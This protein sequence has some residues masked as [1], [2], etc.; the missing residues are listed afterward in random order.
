MAK[1]RSVIDVILGEA[2]GATPQERL[3]EM[4]GIASV[5]ANRAAATGKT[6]EQV[7][8]EDG[9]FDAYNKNIPKGAEAYRGLAEQALGYVKQSGPVTSAT[10]FSASG[11]KAPAKG[12][13]VAQQG[14]ATTFYDGKYGANTPVNAAGTFSPP[15]SG[16][17]GGWGFP[18]MAPPTPVTTTA[19]TGTPGTG[20]QL[21]DNG[22]TPGGNW[23]IAGNYKP[24]VDPRLTDILSTAAA[25]F[26]G[27]EVKAFSGLRPG[28]KRQHGR[29]LATDVK[30]VDKTTGVEVPD[31]QS[32]EG[33]RTYEQFAQVAKEVQHEKYPELDKGF[34]WGGYFSGPPG[35]YGA[36]DLMHFDLGG[37][38][39]LHMAGGT[40][41]HGLTEAQRKNFPGAVSIGMDTIENVPLPE[42]R[43]TQLAGMPDNVGAPVSNPK[44]QLAQALGGFP[45]V[46]NSAEAA[47]LSPAVPGVAPQTKT[48]SL[49]SIAVPSDS[50]GA[51]NPEKLS[52]LGA[53][54]TLTGVSPIPGDWTMGGATPTVLDRM[55][56]PT[57][58]A[59]P[60][61]VADT[62]AQIYDRP[63]PVDPNYT[64]PA[65]PT[66]TVP[67]RLISPTQMGV[68]TPPDVP[69]SPTAT[70]PTVTSPTVA[71]A[72]PEVY[73]AAPP[74]PTN[75]DKFKM[76]AGPIVNDALKGSQFGL[77]GMVAGGLFGAL[78]PNGFDLGPQFDANV[79]SADRFSTGFGLSGIEAAMNGPYGATGFS[80][81]SPGMSYTSLG[82][83]VGTGGVGLRR[84]DKFGYTEVVGPDGSVRGI[85][86]DDPNGGG[87]FGDISRAFGGFFGGKPTDKEKHDFSGKAGLW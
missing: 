77:P 4:L 71:P 37:L 70:Q 41:E 44:P 87:I 81:S 80:L 73:P 42:V 36:A 78:A 68:V 85:H 2:G 20:T 74:A 76:T 34:R 17:P 51:L 29:G 47:P 58:P 14:P 45:S 25:Q 9:Q 62:L 63:P 21:A 6:P 35:K 12:L 38:S 10:F 54:G 84:N 53:E 23:T 72:A 56:P 8:A 66:V 50:Y 49:G 79:P 15:L 60:P 7:V 59:T 61:T 75:W 30:L 40:W 86:Y 24:G 52:P 33:F 22:L 83:R 26:P 13:T 39:G 64:V 43:P 11:T 31:Y 19:V 57:T 1:A 67:D 28:D 48:A 18:G 46:V 16:P 5:I 82:P 55:A 27:Y 32:P 65:K 69:I 3:T